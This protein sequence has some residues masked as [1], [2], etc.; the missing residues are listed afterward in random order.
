MSFSALDCGILSQDSG[1]S[2]LDQASDL[3]LRL[4]M[5]SEDTLTGVVMVRLMD[6]EGKERRDVH[7]LIGQEL[8]G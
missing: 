5:R 4:M 2:V 7:T 3:F 8:S 1:C 6:E